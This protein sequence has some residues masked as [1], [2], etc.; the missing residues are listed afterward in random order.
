MFNLSSLKD[1]DG[2]VP[3]EPEEDER[4]SPRRKAATTIDTIPH[5]AVRDEA[6]AQSKSLT[7]SSAVAVSMVVAA[8]LLGNP[9]SSSS[10]SGGPGSMLGPKRWVPFPCLVST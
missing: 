10:A 9:L 4:G 2:R 3:E 7:S 8:F 6:Q 1:V 5:P